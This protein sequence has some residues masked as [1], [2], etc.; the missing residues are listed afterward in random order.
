MTG[1]RFTFY[2]S[3]EFWKEHV[4]TKRKIDITKLHQKRDLRA[5]LKACFL[6]SITTMPL[7][8]SLTVDRLSCDFWGGDQNAYCTLL[9]HREPLSLFNLREI[10]QIM[11]E[12][13]KKIVEHVT[14]FQLDEIHNE[15]N[16]IPG[17]FYYFLK[18]DNIESVTWTFKDD[19]IRKSVERDFENQAFSDEDRGDY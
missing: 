18:I 2:F 12:Q 3:Y 13:L 5:W 14:E 11:D 8:E 17:T 7:H 15:T 10:R 9:F 4:S 6:H 19:L 16:F 1:V